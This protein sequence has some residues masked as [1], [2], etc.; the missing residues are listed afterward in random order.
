M[1]ENNW[2]KVEN[3]IK[4]TFHV[5]PQIYNILFLIGVQELNYAFEKLDQ[6]TKTKV[7]NFAS[8]YVLKFVSETEKNKLKE[9]YNQLEKVDEL[10][11][12]IYKKAITNY[13]KYKGII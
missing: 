12:Q 11:E 7:L 13:F 2:E 3:F 10:E 6:N 5:E 1:E 4:D 8:M 9:T